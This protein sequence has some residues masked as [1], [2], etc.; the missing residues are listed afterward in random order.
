MKW[1]SKKI[2]S[3]FIVLGCAIEFVFGQIRPNFV[4]VP[5]GVTPQIAIDA[6]GNMHVVT[7]NLAEG[8]ISEGAFYG[9]FDSLGYEIVAPKMISNT[10]ST[11]TPRLAIGRNHVIVVWR[12][13]T[14]YGGGFIHGKLLSM[15]G[16]V[17]SQTL[18]FGED[19]CPS[20]GSPDVA[21]LNDTTYIVVWSGE[22]PLTP[23]NTEGI[24]GQIA[25]TSGRF[26]GSNMVLNDHDAQDLDTFLVRVLSNP[27]SGR[28]VVIWIDDYLGGYGVFARF[29]NNDGT[30]Q[31][32]SFRVSEDPEILWVTDLSAAMDSVGN[33]SVVWSFIRKD[34]TRQIRWRR[35]NAD[36]TPLGN[37]LRVDSDTDPGTAFRPVDIAID[38]EGKCVIVW[39]HHVYGKSKIYAQRFLEHGTP[40]GNAF[41]ISTKQPIHDQTEPSVVLFRN[42]IYT[43]WRTVHPTEPI[44]ITEANILDFENP[45]VA[46]NNQ[47]E[48]NPGDFQLSQNYPNPFN[49]ATTITF[50][51]PHLSHVRLAIYDLSGKRVM[52]L[53][54]RELMPGI[55]RAQWHG[56]NRKGV[57]A[58]SGVYLCTLNINGFE[59][60]RKILLVK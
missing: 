46:I 56:K 8:L 35:F 51:I 48:Q 38:A 19:C 15:T 47:A 22:G 42:R 3:C 28:F 26:I 55:H 2:I 44:F 40:Y 18:D 12:W 20:R 25:T 57:D 23:T 16:D 49:S 14:V 24:Y 60:T 7:E 21:F 58:S 6:Q 41:R 10:N 53:V 54:N 34:T 11:Q 36:G 17:I 4:L 52:T 32:S 29:I 31:G 9:L 59:M 33:I 27:G 45:T 37:S 13:V 1:L 43:A 30:A 39:R 5:K 50:K